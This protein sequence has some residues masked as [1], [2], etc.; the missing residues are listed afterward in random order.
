M[1]PTEPYTLNAL[2][3]KP[4]TQTPKLETLPGPEPFGFL[5]CVRRILNPGLW[6]LNNL[7]HPKP[8][9]MPQAPKSLKSQTRSKP[10]RAVKQ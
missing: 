7:N 4:Q 10:K 6:I 9:V 8:K 3:P 1:N 5:S 2:N